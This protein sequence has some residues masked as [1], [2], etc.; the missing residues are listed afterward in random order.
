MKIALVVD[1]EPL[2]R[3]K[4]SELLES[5]GFDQ[6]V[7]AENGQEAL[8]LAVTHK[9]VLIVMDVTMPVMNGI[10]AA[11]KIGIEAPAPIVLLTGNTDAETINGARDAG[12]MSYLVK[13]FR[14]EQLFPAV[15]LAM[16]QFMAVST[17]QDQVKKLEDTLETRKLVDK[18]KGV[19]MGTGLSEPEAYRKMQKLA[20]S[21]R[22]TLKQVAE[23]IL[24]MAD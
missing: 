7:E 12:V 9:P 3:R 10:N 17:L 23:A 2:I 14:D 6:I 4:V 24:M 8:L 22:K 15:E 19:L 13:P 16:H 18:A 5:Y 21:K 11:K 1:D 20:M